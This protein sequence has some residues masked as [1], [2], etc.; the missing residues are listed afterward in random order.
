MVANFSMPSRNESTPLIGVY[1]A[2]KQVNCGGTCSTAEIF[3][4]PP[5][6][7]SLTLI[8]SINLR[9]LPIFQ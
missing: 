7:E 3:G 4:I 2:V 9:H 8:Y 5:R 1:P 6:N